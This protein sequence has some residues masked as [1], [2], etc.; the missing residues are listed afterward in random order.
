MPWIDP[1]SLGVAAVFLALGLGGAAMILALG[2]FFRTMAEIH[3]SAPDS[4]PSCTE[5]GC[6]LKPFRVL[7]LNTGECPFDPDKPP[8]W[9]C[10][11]CGPGLSGWPPLFRTLPPSPTAC[12]KPRI[13]EV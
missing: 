3:G 11:A 2:R 5:C 4:P 10:S 7:P 12:D 1:E 6:L 9:Y 13:E 8:D